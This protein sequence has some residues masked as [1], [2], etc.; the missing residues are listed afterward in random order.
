MGHILLYIDAQT[1]LYYDPDSLFYFVS[2]IAE[3]VD[4]TYM[5]HLV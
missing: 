5:S 1:F 3:F 2:S 4:D